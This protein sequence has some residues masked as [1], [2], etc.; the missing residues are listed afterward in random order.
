MKSGNGSSF[1]VWI[2]TNFPILHSEAE[3]VKWTRHQPRK[4]C[5]V[6]HR[7]QRSIWKSQFLAVEPLF[8]ADQSDCQK[9]NSRDN[10]KSSDHGVSSTATTYEIKDRND[11]VHRLWNQSK[12]KVQ[13]IKLR[14][15][16]PCVMFGWM[17]EKI[18]Y[19]YDKINHILWTLDHKSLIKP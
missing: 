9:E 16:L 11:I 5:L 10:G 13:S 6:N 12:K 14:S 15:G 8:R 3:T 19:E 17:I 18:F 1:N 2:A 7:K 4:G